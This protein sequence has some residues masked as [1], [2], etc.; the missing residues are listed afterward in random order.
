[1]NIFNCQI[2]FV[3]TCCWF[4]K[5]SNQSSHLVNI[6]ETPSSAKS[7]L[8]HW[9]FCH[10]SLDQKVVSCHENIFPKTII[11]KSKMIQKC[12]SNLRIVLRNLLTFY[13]SKYVQIIDI[14]KTDK[15]A[16]FPPYHQNLQYDDILS[17]ILVYYV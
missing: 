12:I 15:N 6:N 17:M 10:Y 4:K 2:Q 16:F 13:V 9:T 5:I 3:N 7:L 14:D 11:A 1:M 8:I